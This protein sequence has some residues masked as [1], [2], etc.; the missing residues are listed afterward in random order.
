MKSKEKIK[1]IYDLAEEHILKEGITRLNISNLCS[2]LEMSKKTFYKEFQS[3]EQFIKNLYL[4]NLSNSYLE[5]ICIIQKKNSFFEKFEGISK[6]VERGL[7]LFNNNA[8]LELYGKYPQIVSQINSFKEQRIIPMFVL[9]IKK[10]QEHKIINNFEPRIIF[11]IFYLTIS[12]IQ[13]T[14]NKQ[15]VTQRNIGFNDVFNILLKGVLTRKGKNFI[16]YV[17]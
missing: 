12:S 1:K 17:S 11:D 8:I 3:K 4:K 6:I 13:A 5:V 2:C 7:P 9:L 16:N 14:E 10:A 15:I